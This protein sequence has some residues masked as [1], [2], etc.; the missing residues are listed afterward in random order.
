VPPLDLPVHIPVMV[1]EVRAMLAPRPGSVLLDCTLGGGGHAEA[2][3]PL[4]LPGG[5]YVA[6]DLDEGQVRRARERFGWAGE[7]FIAEHGNF[8]RAGEV[9]RS[10]GLRGADGVLAD[11]GF[12]STQMDDPERGFSF[13]RDGPLDMRLD[14]TQELT[15]ASLVNQLPERE[16]ADLIY[17][18]GEERASRR[19]ARKIVERRRREPIL[20]TWA[21]ARVVHEAMGFVRDRAGAA[22]GDR[23]VERPRTGA[24]ID[25]AT[26]TFM[27]LRIAVNGELASL[28]RLLESLPGWLVEGGVAVVISFHSLEDRRVKLAFRSWCQGGGARALTKKPLTPSD[29]QC[30]ANPRA[31]SAKLRAVRSG[32]GLGETESHE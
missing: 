9:L 24:R 2:L 23:P 15:A 25:P 21:L 18:W 22:A 7:A 26:R 17:E 8:T 10:L 1:E 31:R 11:L 29:A 20:T 6:M 30:A 12:A 4:I 14:R 27:A 19:I 16:L 5:R 28:D 32:P 13:T 3:L